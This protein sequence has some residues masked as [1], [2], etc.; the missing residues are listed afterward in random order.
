[1]IYKVEMFAGKCDNCQKE[2]M[3]GQD[4]S[5]LGDRSSIHDTMMDSGWT[6]IEGEEEK[7]YCPDCYEYGDEDEIIIKKLDKK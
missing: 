6:R 2:I 5:C 7:H 1:M 4:Y 3:E